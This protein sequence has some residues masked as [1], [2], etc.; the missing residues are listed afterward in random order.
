M[1]RVDPRIA[2]LYAELDDYVTAYPP[3]AVARAQ[4]FAVGT[5][6]FPVGAGLWWPGTPLAERPIAL[7]AHVFDEASYRFALGA[8]EGSERVAGNRTWAGLR[9][10][11]ALA[12]ADIAD[13]FLTN[14][15]MGIKVG[16]ATGAVRAGVCYRAQCAAYLARQLEVIRPRLVVT[17]G[18][19]A[20]QVLRQAVPALADA[21][22]GFATMA[23]IDAA[24]PPRHI[25]RGVTLSG[26]CVVDIAVLRHPCTWTNAPRRGCSGRGLAADAEILRRARAPAADGARDLR[27]GAQ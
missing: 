2:G 7:I 24:S 1:L 10:V 4:A 22:D 17:L 3:H 16:P 21:W 13:C 15:L 9:R 6:F 19:H 14:A 5:A 25:V 8:G 27:Y 23:A 20:L 12:D 11:L 26:D 18:S